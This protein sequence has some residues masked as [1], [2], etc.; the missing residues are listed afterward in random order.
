MGNRY[1]YNDEYGLLDGMNEKNSLEIVARYSIVNLNDIN[2]GDFFDRKACFLPGR[3]SFRIILLSRRVSEGVKM[4][5]ATVGLNYTLN[6]YI[7]VM[8]EYKYSRL[9]NVYYPMD[10]N[11]HELQ[12][13]LMVSF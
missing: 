8:G 2:K 1:T 13:R 9:S 3:E 4:Q 11:F 10:K 5:A 7:K 12:M 6:Q